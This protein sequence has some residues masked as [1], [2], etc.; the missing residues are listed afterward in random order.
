[1]PAH[2]AVAATTLPSPQQPRIVPVARPYM[3]AA[4]RIL[5]YLERIDEA[6]WYSNFGPL[7]LE[8]ETR[9]ADR[10]TAPAAVATAASG[11]LA[12]T[13]ALKAMGA[14]SG[15]LCAM[16]SWTF[17][18]TAHAAVQAGLIPWF[19]DVDPETWMLRPETVRGAMAAAPRPVGAVIPVCA[20]GRIP[21]LAAWAA[22][23]EDTGLPVLLD[24]AA[25]FD[26]LD[27]LPVPAMVSLHATKVLG[28]GEGGFIAARDQALI[29]HVRT[30]TTFGFSGSRLSN[31][32][33]T[34]AKL[35][36][37]AAA[38]GLASLDGWPAARLRYMLAAQRL[39]M[40]LLATP[41]QFQPGWG[42]DWIS[43]V[44][45][46]RL[47]DGCA[48]QVEARLALAGVDSRRWWGLGCHTSPAFRDLPRTAL[49]ATERLAASTIGLP[50]AMD[51]EMDE[52]DLVAHALAG[53]LG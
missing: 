2:R 20:F 51:L 30:L 5:P 23:G 25:A 47:P 24:A 26:A 1:M 32:A 45:V 44:C 6:R 15:S 17:V 48:D 13:L 19:L 41:V 16:P 38:A 42:V 46:V 31:V 34:N 3:P 43:S 36:E 53:A 40:A 14:A 27:E 29:D 52:I 10:F 12:M 39:R 4:G 9:L 7:L 49:P 28:S 37:Y 22:F 33:A 35:S 18:A 8:F 11:T 21:D 50:F